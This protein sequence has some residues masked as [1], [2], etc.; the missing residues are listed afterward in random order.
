MTRAVDFIKT[1]S[2]AKTPINFKDL[3]RQQLVEVFLSVNNRY[4]SI[5]LGAANMNRDGADFM[6]T[7]KE[8]CEVLNELQLRRQQAT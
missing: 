7:S 5:N 1:I 8:L 4:L 3:T 6:K 2:M